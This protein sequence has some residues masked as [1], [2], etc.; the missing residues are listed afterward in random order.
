VP[1]QKDIRL[2]AARLEELHRSL[3]E[4]ELSMDGTIAK[5]S[6]AIELYRNFKKHFSSSGFDVNVLSRDG[7]GELREQAFDWKALET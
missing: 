1:D 3:R 4:G 7:G 6:E 5:V 2:I